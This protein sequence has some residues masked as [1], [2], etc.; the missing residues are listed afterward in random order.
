M[1]VLKP[2]VYEILNIKKEL[3]NEEYSN[4][5]KKALELSIDQMYNNGH[6][7]YDTQMNIKDNRVK[8]EELFDFLS[9]NENFK[10]TRDELEVEY[11]EF[12]EKISEELIELGINKDSF[13]YKFDIDK[14]SIHICKIFSLDKEFLKNF[15]FLKDDNA[16]E[17]LEKLMKRK[18]FIER[19]AILRLPRILF[20][21]V[22]ICEISENFVLEKTYPYFDA[23]KNCYSIDLVFNIQVEKI[24]NN[25]N[26]NE[27]LE[28]VINIIN[29][30][31]DYYNE[32]M[33]I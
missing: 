7:D 4:T 5:I 17:Y 13:T 27:I 19:F 29:S 22:D 16:D 21:F 9:T 24:L 28:E 14:E 23:N 10:K 18:G 1:K 30:S 26:K 32:R 12:G 3:L 2:I 6:I 11:V 31:E 8:E 25:D 15:F 33:Y 20:D